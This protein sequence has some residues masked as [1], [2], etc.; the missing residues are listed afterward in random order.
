[1]THGATLSSRKSVFQLGQPW[2]PVACAGHS[3]GEEEVE[4]ERLWPPDA[5]GFL[6]YVP[7][8]RV[9]RH[10]YSDIA[11][12]GGR[13]EKPLHFLVFTRFVFV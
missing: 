9:Y 4:E 3:L 8:R 2:L 1:M 5:G 6:L 10:Q 11:K 13:S 12:Y 7:V